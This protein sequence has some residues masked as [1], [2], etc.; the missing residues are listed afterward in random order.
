MLTHPP[1]TSTRRNLS[2]DPSRRIHID[3][4]LISQIFTLTK[5]VLT[6]QYKPQGLDGQ[7]T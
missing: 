7:H 1:C 3:T 2:T 5:A 6:D 4:I